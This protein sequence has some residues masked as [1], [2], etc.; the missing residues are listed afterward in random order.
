[1]RIIL[2]ELIPFTFEKASPESVGIPTASIADFERRLREENVG[3]QG[4]MLYRRGKLVA[5]SIAEPYRSCDKRHVYSVSKSWTSTAIGIAADEGLI[6]LE[7]RL[8]DF[9]PE[10]LP[11]TVSDNLAAMRIKHL[12]S[13]NTGHQTD[14][15]GRVA[16]REPGWAKRFLSLPVENLPGTHFAYNSTATY[17]LSAIITRVTGMRMVD[18][19]R[20]RLFAPLGISGVWWEESPEGVSD[21]G[22]GIHVSPEDMLKLGVLYLNRGVWNGMRIL[23]E[24]YISVA[25]S[26]VSDNSSGG[27]IDWKLGYGYK[28]WRCQHNSYRADGAYGQYIIVSPDKES[29]AVII[30]E[31]GDMQKILDIYWDTVFAAMTDEPCPCEASAAA[32]LSAHPFVTCPGG[33]ELIEPCE[34][35]VSDSF[36][37]IGRVGLSCVGDKL[38]LK[39]WGQDHAVEL[40]CGA[41]E[42]V[43]NHVPHL[44]VSPA[45]F[46]GTLAFGVSADIAAAW[47]ASGR[48]VTVRLQFV[49]T[50]HGMTLEFDRGAGKLTLIPTLGRGKNPIEL[51]LKPIS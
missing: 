5:E 43:Y 42:W 40:V 48:L 12:L 38:V 15:L 37:G 13:M 23:S 34:F 44:P 32:D 16:S 24:D 6:S 31:E 30:S 11:E 26:A 46:I 41:K 22:W 51:T 18:Y 21:G 19:L 7:D 50:P 3:H 20:A 29:V 33:G 17:M 8:I 35:T 9:F 1:M 27:S 36:T 10:L 47:G 14:T 28:W 25:T 2:T 45:A 49:S 39:L 4:Y